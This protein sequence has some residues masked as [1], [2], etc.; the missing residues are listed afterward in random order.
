MRIE[1]K[2]IDSIALMHIQPILEPD[3][4][5]RST[6][7]YRFFRDKIK[8]FLEFDPNSVILTCYN[9]D[10]ISG[11]LVYTRDERAFNRFCAPTH[12]RFWERALKTLTGYYGFSF[13]KFAKAAL[14][15]LG[16]GGGKLNSNTDSLDDGVYGKIWVLIVAEEERGKGI[17]GK[18]LNQ[19]VDAV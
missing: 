6:A 9:D 12:W 4:S 18:L 1:E 11:V 15:M 5:L 16:S 17:A 19:C 13:A 10:L 14:S 3:S 2:H 8:L 7:A